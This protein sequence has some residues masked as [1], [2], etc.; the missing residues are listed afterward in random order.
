MSSPAASLWRYSAEELAKVPSLSSMDERAYELAKREA[1]ELIVRIGSR[2][3]KRLE[4]VS[5]ALVLLQRYYSRR[6]LQSLPDS[7]TIAAACLF[8]AS[9]L[10]ECAKRPLA[11]LAAEFL[12]YRGQ[13][14]S[15]ILDRA[16]KA[17][18]ECEESLIIAERALLSATNYDCEV[19][20]PWQF[21]SPAAKALSLPEPVEKLAIK[22]CN[23]ALRSTLVLSATPKELAHASIWTAL[24]QTTSG[25]AAPVDTVP[26]LL[27]VLTTPVATMEGIR[28]KVKESFALTA[29]ATTTTTAMAMAMTSSSSAA[30]SSGLK[31]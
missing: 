22:I 18:V 12:R 19:P 13:P 11:D 17:F 26:G 6:H 1:T 2:L 20:L 16:G 30:A 24:Q 31:G 21:L 23:E 3:Y 14:E 7:F 9:K 4:V 25:G 8:L 5:S 10:D 27:T 15:V 28:E 29:A